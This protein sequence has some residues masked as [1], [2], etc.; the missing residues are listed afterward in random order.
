MTRFCSNCGAPLPEDA[1]FCEECGTVVSQ[2]ATASPQYSAQPQQPMMPPPAA[3]QQNWQNQGQV[4]QQNWQGQVPQQNWQN[5]GQVPQQNWQGQGQ[6]LRQSWQNPGGIPPYGNIPPA[7][8]KK[9]SI[10]PIILGGGALAI[11]IIAGGLFFLGRE[12]DGGGKNKDKEAWQSAVKDKDNDKDREEDSGKDSQDGFS[13]QDSG[14]TA[15]ADMGDI[16]IPAGASVVEDAS[17]YQ[18]VN[19]WSGEIQI[20]E[21][22][23]FENMD[24]V[25]A[26]IGE[27]KKEVL[28]SP[29][30][31]DLEIEEDGDWTMNLDLMHGMRMR[32][33]DMRIQEP[34]TLEEANAHLIQE[35]DRGVFTVD[36]FQQTDEKEKVQGTGQI[37]LKGAL[38]E[39]SAGRLIAGRYEVIL[40]YAD[41]SVMFGGDYTVRPQKE[42]YRP[43][44]TDP[45]QGGIPSGMEGTE[46]T[47]D[48][49]EAGFG[50]GPVVSGNYTPENYSIIGGG[51]EQLQSGEWIYKTQGGG[52]AENTWIDNEDGY[53]S[54]VGFDGCMVTK[55]YTPDGFWVDEEGHWDRSVPQ[56]MDDPEPLE[57]RR[58]GDSPTLTF[59]FPRMSDGKNYCIMTRSYSFGYEETFSLT[60]VGHGAYMTEKTDDPGIRGLLTVAENQKSILFSEA[61]YTERYQLLE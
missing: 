49:P 43:E 14:S 15:S 18:L 47:V 27:I 16:V 45:G 37:F 56:R 42:E 4:P 60:P 52:T 48:G 19:E 17:F 41:T 44:G 10:L 12:K 36:I 54:Y 25:P 58:Y 53:Y 2:P 6:V 8:P 57:G 50:E 23:G 21:F 59:R 13:G 46:G 39:D 1:R 11:L 3:A 32:G 24:G 40:D 26:D 9:K 51:W 20:T 29:V 22:D 28:A 35:P 7:P 55:N 34:K 61:G 31:A 30:S 38:C 5:Q 33:R